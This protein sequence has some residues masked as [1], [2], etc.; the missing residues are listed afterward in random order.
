MMD[1]NM[2]AEIPKKGH[3]IPDRGGPGPMPQQGAGGSR[4]DEIHPQKM[5]QLVGY[6]DQNAD[7]H[8]EARLH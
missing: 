4:G 6:H 2:G 7:R 3:M 8:E 1:S 5:P